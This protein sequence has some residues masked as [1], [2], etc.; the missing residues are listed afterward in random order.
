MRLCFGRP[1]S[2]WLKMPSIPVLLQRCCQLLP[3]NG[4]V[5]VRA[6]RNMIRKTEIAMENGVKP[7]KNK[8]DKQFLLYIC[9]SFENQSSFQIMNKYPIW[10]F[11]DS[12]FFHS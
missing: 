2:Q 8:M 10:P 12:V 7:N 6:A 11:K 9:I 1:S 3:E 5:L 4:L